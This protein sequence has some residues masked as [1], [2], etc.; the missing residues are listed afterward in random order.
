[1]APGSSKRK[2]SS[3]KNI[4]YSDE[5]DAQFAYSVRKEK[6]TT[7]SGRIKTVYIEETLD[8]DAEPPP[9]PAREQAPPPDVVP[10]PEPPT[11][12][13]DLGDINLPHRYRPHK[14]S[15][16][17]AQIPVGPQTVPICRHKKIIL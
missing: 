2:R 4:M 17:P 14:V 10:L 13:I 11:Y 9:L 1:M 12:D 7:A 8:D 3:Q 5:A 6:V 16:P 15:I